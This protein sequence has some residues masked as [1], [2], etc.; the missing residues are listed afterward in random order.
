V[1]WSPTVSLCKATKGLVCGSFPDAVTRLKGFRNRIPLFLYWACCLLFL[2]CQPVV[3][4]GDLFHPFFRQHRSLPDEAYRE[5]KTFL[6]S[7]HEQFFEQGGELPLKVLRAPSNLILI[8][9]NDLEHSSY[10]ARELQ[11]PFLFYSRSGL[12][13]LEQRGL[14][15]PLWDFFFAI[16]IFD[17]NMKFEN[18][19][20]AAWDDYQKSYE[21]LAK[22]Y[23]L[24]AHIAEDM[25]VSD[26]LNAETASD[27]YAEDFVEKRKQAKSDYRRVISQIKERR[28]LKSIRFNDAYLFELN[29]I[30]GYLFADL[31]VSILYQDSHKMS[32][33]LSESGIPDWLLEAPYRS[34]DR[35]KSRVDDSPVGYKFS[36]FFSP[37]RAALWENIAQPGR[38]KQ[39]QLQSLESLFL[40]MRVL[41]REIVEDMQKV[42]KRQHQY[43]DLGD[44]LQ[45][46]LKN[47]KL[48][49]QAVNDRLKHGY[50][51]DGLASEAP[52]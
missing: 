18:G 19:E 23:L 4:A 24:E 46:F 32:S 15:Y 52:L 25:Y 33:L 10:Q 31:F 22:K 13:E 30:C 26:G 20:L 7:R 35:E 9:L 49:R 8:L 1:Q 50:C 44:T 21:L 47:L 29:T 27:I 6:N 42:G 14:R 17:A 3:Y 36:R 45:E 51:E 37:L 38:T 48:D 16:S 2:P 5:V 34:F 43:Q 11:L 12:S 28:Q 40:R 41:I 39:M